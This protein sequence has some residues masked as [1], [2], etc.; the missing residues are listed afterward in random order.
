MKPLLRYL[1]K[2]G[3]HRKI[4]VA[5][6]L[7]LCLLPLSGP[8]AGDDQSS[9]PARH[10]N[11]SNL[12][13]IKVSNPN[14]LTFAVFGD[15]RDNEAVFGQLLKQ[16]DQDP[17]FAFAV[18]VGDLVP[19]GE[20]GNFRSF[21][22]QVKHYLRLPLL[23]VIGNHDIQNRGRDYYLL[24]FGQYYYSFHLNNNYFIMVDDAGI[25]SFTEKQLRWLAEELQKSQSF[26]R[27]FVFLHIPLFDP[28]QDTPP[29]ALAPEYGW[30]LADLFKK[31][32]VT[33]IF[34]GHIHGYYTG[35][36]SGVPYTIT[37]GGGAP[38]HGTDPQYYFF[39]YLKVTVNGDQVRIQVQ[40]VLEPRSPGSGPQPVKGYQIKDP[41]PTK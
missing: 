25:T 27:R 37:G 23:T 16:V 19:D 12:S 38:L 26:Q 40:R 24:I 14:S 11:Q 29:H 1:Y 28:R 17:D 4:Q 21:I 32:K 36:W 15:S 34:T 22:K 5:L 41:H 7:V 9:L 2:M 33:H 13:R 3:V 39:H 20:L 10:W 8:A 31:Y 35:K 6:I 30:R 18:Q